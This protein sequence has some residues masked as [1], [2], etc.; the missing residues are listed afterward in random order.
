MDEQERLNTLNALLENKK[1]IQ[2]M[3]AKMPLESGRMERQ[4]KEL[5]DKLVDIERGIVIMSKK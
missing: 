1:T 4:K 3:I 5:N 2:G